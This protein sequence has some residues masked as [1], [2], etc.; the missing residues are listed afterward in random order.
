MEKIEVIVF[1]NQ[2]DSVENILKNFNVP[3]VRI[4]A[5]SESDD[6]FLYAITV[7]EDMADEVIQK[8][9]EVVDLKQKNVLL[10]NI[11][12]EATFLII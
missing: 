3:H 6:C 2:V 12:T 4:T 10:N 8:L 9:A 7:P 1:Q 5:K 11:K